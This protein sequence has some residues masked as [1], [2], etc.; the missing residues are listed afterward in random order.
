MG[1]IKINKELLEI[2]GDYNLFMDSP[3]STSMPLRVT[4]N[5]NNHPSSLYEEQTLYS[6]KD[7]GETMIDCEVRYK[8]PN[9]YSFQIL[10]D[11]LTN[12]VLARL[13]EGNGTHRNN[14]KDIPLDQQMITT[15]HFHKYDTKG[16]FIAYKTQALE[17]TK[18]SPLP[19]QEGFQLFCQEEK[20]SSNNDFAI[21]IEIQENGVLPLEHDNDPLNGIVF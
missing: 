2:L 19:I 21:S 18:S 15:P 20:I 1:H 10:I 16:R 7:L 5:K 4:K 17:E 12:K 8:N 9:N 14:C 6:V 11:H 13:D 3:K